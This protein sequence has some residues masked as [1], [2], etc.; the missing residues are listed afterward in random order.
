[1]KSIHYVLLRAGAVFVLAS[2]ENARERVRVLGTQIVDPAF[3][4]LLGAV[5]DDASVEQLAKLVSD[6]NP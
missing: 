4:R 2:N 5:A 3:S 1:M 6:V